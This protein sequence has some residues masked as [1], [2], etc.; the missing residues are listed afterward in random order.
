[1][2]KKLTLITLVGLALGVL[3]PAAAYAGFEDVPRDHWAY[4]AVDYL[5]DEGFLIGYPDGTY[6]GDRMLTRYEFAMVTS[7]IYDQFLDLLA[8][9][10]DEPPIEIGAV[11]DMLMDEFEPE[12]AE[13]RDLINS[14]T[15]RIDTLEGYVGDFE[16]A[17][18]DLDSRLDS[19]D[20]RF[21]PYGDLSL[22]F[23]GVY[24]DDGLQAQRPQFQM[25]VGFT[26]QINDELTMG[27][28]FSSGTE[29]ARQSGYQTFNDAFGFDNNSIDMAYMM[30]QPPGVSGFTMW[31]G[32]FKA[33][34]TT[35]PM[36]WDGDVTVEGLAQ[37]YAWNDFDF[38]L[39]E[40][41]PAEEGFYLLAQAGISDLLLEDSHLAVTYHYINSEAWQHIRDDMDSGILT[42]KW[43]FS[44]LESPDD[45]RAIEVYWSW[46]SDVM[47][48]PFKIKANFLMN[49]E[50]TA[51]GL[52]DEAGWQQ[53]AWASLAFNDLTLV[54]P[55]DWNIWGEY[56]RIQPNS[57]LPW[58]NDA[59][60]GTTDTEFWLVGWKY[61]LLR[62][63]DLTVAYLEK[64]TLS[65]PPIQYDSFF[66]CIST[67]FK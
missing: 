18:T 44:R 49:L 20:A 54:D 33:P 1:M 27:A 38:Y 5:A 26:S 31:G 34:W 2:F 24:P 35:T 17:I 7:R 48:V 64:E 51:P 61:R 60:R 62:S 50:D 59:W 22:R 23:Y 36:V 3:V 40:L 52:A 58:L 63:T 47:D 25:H 55:G 11:V 12:I 21:H 29:G 53:A 39:G 10:G 65:H 42:N 9:Y 16:S 8:D 57:A 32:K 28:R 13:L 46:K 4:D 19:M 43:N 14:N 67:Y 45:Y 41:V 37:H 30:W 6:R 66:V 15:E 56:G